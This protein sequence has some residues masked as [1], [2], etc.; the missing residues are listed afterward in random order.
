MPVPLGDGRPVAGGR[1][2]DLPGDGV[3]LR[4]TR[5]SGTG[6][7]LLLLHGLASTRRFYNLVVP[8]LLGHPML[9]LDARG[10]GDSERADAGYDAMSLVRDLTTALDALGISRV[11]AVGHSWG[12]TLALRLAAEAPERAL[13]VVALDG[14]FATRD[15]SESRATRRARLMP[16]D[17]ALTPEDLVSRLRGGPLGPWWSDEVA[18][19]VL[20]VFEVF[21]DGRA[22]ARLSRE[23]HLACLDD[24]LDTDVEAVLARVRCPAWLV[25]CEPVVPDAWALAKATGLARAGEL[26]AS[27]RLIRLAGAIHDVPLQWPALIA[28]LVQTAAVDVVG[29]AR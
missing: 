14:G 20:P 12:A 23:R 27:P 1:D 6:V 13:A 21:P 9:A 22:R 26:L 29:G 16:P 4:G 2:L 10:H 17:L 24:L 5:W 25:S 3:R 19:A 7:P 8:G 28:G 11:V 18:Q 15:A